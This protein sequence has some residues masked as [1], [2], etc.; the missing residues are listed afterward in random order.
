M[1]S[2]IEQHFPW[3]PTL[4]EY[5]YDRG[6]IDPIA[7]FDIPEERDYYPIYELSLEEDGYY[8]WFYGS[9]IEESKDWKS[10]VA[11]FVKKL[12]NSNQDLRQRLLSKELLDY[13]DDENSFSLIN[14][15]INLVNQNTIIEK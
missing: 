4:L 6:K 5:D 11:R 1:I 8:L 9:V 12:I 15:V 2:K 10:L 3:I 14:M 7:I 13:W